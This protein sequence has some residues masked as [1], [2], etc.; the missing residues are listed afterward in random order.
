MKKLKNILLSVLAIIAVAVFAPNVNA[1]EV[2]SDYV[3]NI[4]VAKS[5]DNTKYAVAIA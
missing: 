5:E 3:S 2:E 1:T 4:V